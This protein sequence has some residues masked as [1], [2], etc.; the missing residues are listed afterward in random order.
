MSISPQHQVPRERGSFF[1][2]LI[3]PALAILVP[4]GWS[5]YRERIAVELQLLSQ[6]VLVDAAQTPK[7]VQVTY[8]QRSVPGLS[9]VELGLVNSGRKAIRG[10][11]V[12]T[13]I[14]VVIDSGRILDVLT[15]RLTPENL[16]VHFTVDTT[17][18]SVVVTTPLLNPGDGVRFTLLIGR[19]SPPHV[20]ASARIVGLH[21]VS[22][23]DRRPEM[24]PLWRTVPWPIYLALLGTVVTF[25]FLVVALYT[26][27][28]SHR[29]RHVWRERHFFLPESPTPEQYAGA[30]QICIGEDPALASKVGATI[31]GLVPNRQIPQPQLDTLNKAVEKHIRNSRVRVYWTIVVLGLFSTAGALFVTFSVV[32]AVRGLAL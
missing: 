10:Q 11:D 5:L 23:A 21:R 3:L 1:F 29:A 25:L 30:L 9:R 7:K 17:R 6:S 24:R 32:H 26:A 31:D 4:I 20:S 15:D 27:G 18:Q 16:Q 19:T 28:Y 22:L 12:T 13:P 2:R 8:D 14:T